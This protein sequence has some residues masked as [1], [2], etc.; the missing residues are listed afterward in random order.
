MVEKV[1]CG[2]ITVVVFCANVIS[3][4]VYDQFFWLKGSPSRTIG[5]QYK[6]Y[7]LINVI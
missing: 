4:N 7:S 2:K 5:F 3:V 1:L 6:L